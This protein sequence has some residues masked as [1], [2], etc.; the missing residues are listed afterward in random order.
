[1]ILHRN[2]LKP[3]VPIILCLIAATTFAQTT[4]T[5]NGTGGYVI[6]DKS[7]CNA[8][9][10]AAAGRCL[11]E[12]EELRKKQ[13]QQAQVLEQQRLENLRLQNELLKKKLEQEQQATAKSSS[14]QGSDSSFLADPAFADWLAANR[15]FGPDRP[16]TEFAMLYA[17]Q[18]KSDKPDLAGRKFLDA[19][20]TKVNEVFGD[21]K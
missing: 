7:G 13:A 2:L 20:A 9:F 3:L 10:G 8:L 17:K 16:R 6:E 19:V 21:S 4:V 1:M 12:Q 15:W 14:E 11:R 18:L 5:P